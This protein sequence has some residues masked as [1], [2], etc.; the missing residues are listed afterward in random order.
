MLF[1]L[2]GKRRRV[3]Q[4]TYLTLAVL[5]GAGLV[6][7]GV[8]SGS[9]FGGL[10][11]AITGKG[12]SSGGSVSGVV[13]KRIQR[14]Q[15]ALR[16][17]PQ[18]QAA[19]ADMIRARYQ[20]ATDDAD[21]NTGA[22]GPEGKKQLA[23]ADVAWKKYVAIVDKPSDSLASLMLQA[24]QQGALNKPADAA[25]AAEII[26]NARPSAQTYLNLTTFATQAGDTRTAKLAGLKAVEL[27]PKN[28]KKQV[29]KEVVI[30]Q[31]QGAISP[32]QVT[33]QVGGGSG[34]GG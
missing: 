23:Q 2:T 33:P 29:K 30:A 14:D 34:S 13:N 32:N 8:G 7:F 25:K 9:G 27:A 21:A 28:Q 17:N 15:K 12:S 26:A 4:A 24:Y 1:D 22:F 6:L 11:D 5:M 10:W 19:L 31:A 3:V 18:N 16:L 20:L